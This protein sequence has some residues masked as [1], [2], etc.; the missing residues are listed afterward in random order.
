MSF[1]ERRILSELFRNDFQ[2]ARRDIFNRRRQG[3]N[4]MCT[5]ADDEKQKRKGRALNR[6]KA[7]RRFTGGNYFRIKSAAHSSRNT[8]LLK[9][10]SQLANV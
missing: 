3:E 2:A 5:L 1:Y 10:E 7:H 6:Q 8:L 4:L 9:A